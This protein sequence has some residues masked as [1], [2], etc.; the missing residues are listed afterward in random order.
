MKCHSLFSGENKKILSIYR[1]MNL[2]REWL[3]LISFTWN[4]SSEIN[5]YVYEMS[6]FS[7]PA[8]LWK[9]WN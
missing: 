4:V 7:V 3:R 1:L 2:P 5:Q 6:W 9:F 8:V